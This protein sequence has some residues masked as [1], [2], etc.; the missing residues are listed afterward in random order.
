MYLSRIHVY[1]VEDIVEEQL[2]SEVRVNSGQICSNVEVIQI[3][4]NIYIDSKSDN[5]QVF[6]NFNTNMKKVDEQAEL[7]KLYNLNKWFM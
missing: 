3:S 1:F 4:N 6:V 5:N 7:N 2:H